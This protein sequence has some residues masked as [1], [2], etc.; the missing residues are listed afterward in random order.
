MPKSDF[1]VLIMGV[2]HMNAYF[3]FNKRGKKFDR[4]PWCGG[5]TYSIEQ[6]AADHSL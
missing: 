3:P 6:E 1:V 2:S 5:A 4:G